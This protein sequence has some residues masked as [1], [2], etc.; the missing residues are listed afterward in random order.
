M[1]NRLLH[2]Y[3][4]G[5]HLLHLW[6]LIRTAHTSIANTKDFTFRHHEEVVLSQTGRGI[7]NITFTVAMCAWFEIAS[8]QVQM[9]KSLNQICDKCNQLRKKKD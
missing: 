1:R 8:S 4:T 5:G 9:N 6:N 7:T 2:V 3:E